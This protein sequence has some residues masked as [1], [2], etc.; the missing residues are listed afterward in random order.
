MNKLIFIILIFFSLNVSASQVYSTPDDLFKKL[1][2]E[3][4]TRVKRVENTS[5][6]NGDGLN[7]SFGVIAWLPKDNT[8]IYQA[9]VFVLLKKPNG[10]Y[11]SSGLSKEFV[12]CDFAKTYIEI[13]EKSANFS[14][15]IQFNGRSGCATG[16]TV[17]RFKFIENR[18][19]LTGKDHSETNCSDTGGMVEWKTSENYLTD[20][21]TVDNKKAVKLKI[22][23]VFIDDFSPWIIK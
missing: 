5:D 3:D 11:E 21:E 20:K 8:G 22:P 19:R 18:W 4:A 6:L 10:K 23:P 14:F 16:T 7:D 1:I 9:R 15:Y 17:F 12:C 13:V 2:P